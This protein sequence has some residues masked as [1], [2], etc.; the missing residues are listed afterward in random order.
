M[1]GRAQA[2]QTLTASVPEDVADPVDGLGSPSYTYQWFRVSGGNA[3]ATGPTYPLESADIGSQ[4]RAEASFTD[5]RSNAEVLSSGAYP[6]EGRVRGRSNADLGSLSVDGVGELYVT[7]D[8]SL[9]VSL[10]G[11]TSATESVML[12]FELAQA[13]ASCQVKYSPNDLQGNAALGSA[14]ELLGRAACT[15][16]GEQAVN[17]TLEP[18]DNYVAI[19]VRAEAGNQKRF[20]VAL[21]REEEPD[22]TLL[23]EGQTYQGVRYSFPEA[24][25]GMPIRIVL[26][27]DADVESDYALYRLQGSTSIK[28]TSPYM[29]SVQSGRYVDLRVAAVDDTEIEGDEVFMVTLRWDGPAEL[30]GSGV[31]GRSTSTE[32]VIT[33]NDAA[34]VVSFGTGPYVAIEGGTAA[35]VLVNLSAASPGSLAIPLIT[36]NGPGAE[37]RGDY[38][39]NPSTV[40]FSPG[41]TSATVT[42]TDVDDDVDDDMESV[43]LRFGT[44]PPN[45]TAVAPITATVTLTDDDDPAVMVSYDMSIYEVREEEETT[46]EVTVG[47]SADPEREVEIQITATGQGGAMPD[48]DYMGVPTSVTFMSGGSLTKNFTVTAVDD[49]IDD[50][51]ES[52]LLGFGTP[53]GV[54]AGSISEAEVVLLGRRCGANGVVH[55]ERH[56]RERGRGHGDADGDDQRHGVR[57]GPGA[58]AGVYGDGDG[59]E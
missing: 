15:G 55:G 54:S 23:E 26:S 34:A 9:Y 13:D 36:S 44:L 38:S 11:I 53:D 47:L 43:V 4:V 24:S 3:I 48:Q 19:L 25:P 39:V 16:T 59:A 56:R 14:T 17:V 1:T 35:E 27:G 28:L 2:G 21:Y 29:A 37:G 42:V 52:V 31:G 12:M 5:F 32:Y 22:Y 7:Q 6:P 40:L 41:Q 10:S 30:Q 18:G 58:D 20:I 51:G 46:A 57:R 45:L 33:D 8:G 50:D 49:N